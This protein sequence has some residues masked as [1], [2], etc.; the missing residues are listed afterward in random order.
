MCS[1]QKLLELCIRVFEI[2]FTYVS[3]LPLSW[4]VQKMNRI[5]NNFCCNTRPVFRLSL[6]KTPVVDFANASNT[7]FSLY[8]AAAFYIT[9][10]CVRK[11]SREEDSLMNWYICPRP[12]YIHAWIHRT[13]VANSHCVSISFLMTSIIETQRCTNC[14]TYLFYRLLA[15]GRRI[16]RKR[17]CGVLSLKT[18]T[19]LYTSF[20]RLWSNF[21]FSYSI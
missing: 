3:R 11:K 2:N 7:I 17:D 12:I 14:L 4:W 19:C 1:I 8:V 10:C 6:R 9:I 21:A 18:C 16:S 15:D 20:L 13:D 5:N